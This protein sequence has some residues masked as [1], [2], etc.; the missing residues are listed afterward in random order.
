MPAK[1]KGVKTG[2]LF[3]GTQVGHLTE[4]R[5]RFDKNT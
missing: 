5:M 4:E 3:H 2:T 1:Q